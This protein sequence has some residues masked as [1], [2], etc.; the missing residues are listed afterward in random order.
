MFA[1]KTI[2]LALGLF[3]AFAAAAAISV[4]FADMTM[5]CT[6]PLTHLQKDDVSVTKRSASGE[7][8]PYWS[9][10]LLI[11][12]DGQEVKRV[13][14]IAE[15]YWSLALLVNDEGDVVKIKRI[16]S[17]H[18]EPYWSVALLANENE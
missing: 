17:A 11:N 16:A 12:D 10:A 18:P 6:T 7:P 3:S 13:K 4:S 9:M 8:E 1:K 14:R 15:P 2:T 5:R